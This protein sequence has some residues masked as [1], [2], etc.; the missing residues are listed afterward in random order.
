MMIIPTITLAFYITWL[1]RNDRFHFLPNLSV[2]LWISANSL[3][4]LD[5]FFEVGLMIWSRYTF[6]AGIATILYWIVFIMPLYIKNKK[7]SR[8]KLEEPYYV[9]TQKV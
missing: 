9:M 3:W 1:S 4:M 2:V 8:K 5:E 7:K 6:I